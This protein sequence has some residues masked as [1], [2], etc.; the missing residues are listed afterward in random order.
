[1]EILVMMVWQHDAINREE[2]ACHT[3]KDAKDAVPAHE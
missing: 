3:K 2:H 1:M